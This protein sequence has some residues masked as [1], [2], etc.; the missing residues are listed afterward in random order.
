MKRI[1]ITL[2]DEEYS[3]LETQ[4]QTQRRSVR[5]MAG[6]LVARPQPILTFQPAPIISP[7]WNPIWPPN[8]W[9]GDLTTRPNGYTVWNSP[10]TCNATTLDLTSGSISTGNAF[11]ADNVIA[12]NGAIKVD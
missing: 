3:L 8:V 1:T 7:P 12:I 6:F 2:T 9:S 5:E 11:K 4:A 10:N